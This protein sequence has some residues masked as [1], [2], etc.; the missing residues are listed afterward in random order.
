LIKSFVGDVGVEVSAVLELLV[1]GNV[2]ETG[3]DYL[4]G[5]DLEL[6]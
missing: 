1:L 5:A 3:V 2:S 6:N 4:S